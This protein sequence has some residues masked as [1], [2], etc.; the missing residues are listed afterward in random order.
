MGLYGARSEAL[1]EGGSDS[2]QDQGRD[3]RIK[4]RLMHLAIKMR[5]RS[6][7]RLRE[8]DTEKTSPQRH[9]QVDRRI[10]SYQ[11]CISCAVQ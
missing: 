7:D 9:E 11:G 4:K 6:G 5:L 8:T 10:G 1:E 2:T 3:G